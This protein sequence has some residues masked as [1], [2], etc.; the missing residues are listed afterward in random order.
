[1]RGGE[2]VIVGGERRKKQETKLNKNKTGRGGTFLRFFGYQF[3]WLLFK[4]VF[5]I[6]RQANSCFE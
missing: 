3:W 2:A 5:E 1:M 6:E 4:S